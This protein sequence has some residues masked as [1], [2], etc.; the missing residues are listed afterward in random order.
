MEKRRVCGCGWEETI[1]SHTTCC[2]ESVTLDRGPDMFCVS[3]S[4][5]EDNNNHVVCV[6]HVC[7]CSEHCRCSA[8]DAGVLEASDASAIKFFSVCFTLF[9]VY[10]GRPAAG[11]LDQG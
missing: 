8:S 7:G 3:S 4:P 2:L 5:K 10:K 6:L 9:F 1:T 11:P